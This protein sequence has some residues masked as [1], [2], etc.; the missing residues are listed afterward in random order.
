MILPDVNTY[1][2]AYRREAEAHERYAAWL[3]ELVAG[4][5]ELALVDHCLIGFLRIVTN[6]RIVTDPAPMAEALGLVIRLRRARRA[7]HVSSTPAVWLK[8]DELVAEDRGLK[9]NLV[10]DAYLAALAISHGC[11]LATADRG[12]ARFNGLD[13]FDPIAN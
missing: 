12:F 7:R 1:V 5:D 11:R 3:G 8:F 4:R 6:P 13:Y 9:A 10:P 2:Y